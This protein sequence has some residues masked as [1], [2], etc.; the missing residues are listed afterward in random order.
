MMAFVI[1][2]LIAG[3]ILFIFTSEKKAARDPENASMEANLKNPCWWIALVI[4][5]FTYPGWII[6]AT[7][8]EL[9]NT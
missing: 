9:K 5:T 7:Y 4:W 1:A 2:Y 8:D 6:W 3:I